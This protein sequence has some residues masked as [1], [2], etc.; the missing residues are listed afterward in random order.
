MKNTAIIVG[1]LLIGVGLVAYFTTPTIITD[2]VSGEQVE[3]VRSWTALIPA[4][5]GLPILL[6]GVWSTVAPAA[7]KMAMHIA[8]TLGLL[9]GLASTGRAASSLLDWVR[10]SGAFN[11]RAFA[12]LAIMA[13]LCWMFVI[14][15]VGSF[16]KARKAREREQAGT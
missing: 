16:I 9:G 7:N 1:L 12:F 6:C 4:I 8:V 15:G 10:G 13:I 14:F 2:S 11:Q 5:V 3:K